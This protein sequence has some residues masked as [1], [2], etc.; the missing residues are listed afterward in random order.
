MSADKLRQDA[1]AST[2]GT[3]YQLCVAVQKCYEMVDGQ[4]VLIESEA[5]LKSLKLM[6]KSILKA[7]AANRYKGDII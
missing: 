6:S 4:K 3:I 7:T 1:T 5:L 2:K